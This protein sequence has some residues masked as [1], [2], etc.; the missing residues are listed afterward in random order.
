MLKDKSWGISKLCLVLNWLH[1]LLPLTAAY[2]GAST[3]GDKAASF[4]AR[5]SVFA[6]PR[7]YNVTVFYSPLPPNEMLP[8]THASHFTHN[9]RVMGCFW[10]FLLEQWFTARR[11]VRLKSGAQ[12]LECHII[13]QLVMREIWLQIMHLAST[14]RWGVGTGINSVK[15]VSLYLTISIIRRKCPIQMNHF[16]D[17]YT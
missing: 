16:K 8:H 14:L 4:L 13:L 10:A 7:T 1:N 2:Q 11:R 9:A 6:I 15:R 17:L 12:I 5:S 3:L